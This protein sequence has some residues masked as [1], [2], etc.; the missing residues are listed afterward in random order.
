MNK[1]GQQSEVANLEEALEAFL[2]APPEGTPPAVIEAFA[3]AVGQGGGALPPRLFLE[4]VRQSAVAIS[5][6]DPKANIL[7]ANPAFG[8]VTG[9]SAEDIVGKNE[10]LL[11]DKTTPSVVYETMWGRLL[12]K[13]SWS[14]V[15][16]NRRK[17]GAR[18]LAELTI[19]PVLD[20]AGN[21]THYLGMHRDVTEVHRLEQQVK[22]QKALIESMVDAAPVA[23]ALLD[24]EGRVVLDNMA[25]KTLS[26]EMGDAEPAE[27]FL[28][29][30]TRSM[31]EAFE[32]LKTSRSGFDNKEVNFEPGNGAPP[33]WFSCSGTWFRE[34]DES[35][36][37]FFEARKETYLLLVA[38][39]IT[40]LKQQQE[41]VRM[42]ALGA[43]LAE[44]ELV[45]GM[46]ET[47]AGAV[48]QL[49][50][51]CNLI[52]AATTMMERR[53]ESKAKSDDPLLSVMRETLSAGRDAIETL[54]A[55]MP[56]PPDE[57]SVSVNINQVI[58]E[59]LTLCTQ[60]M[61][62]S[63]VVVDWQPARVLP[64]LSAREGRLRSMFKQL[65]DNAIDAMA[66]NAGE[67]SVLSI[68]TDVLDDTLIVHLADTGPGIPDD[69]HIKVFEPFYTTKGAAGR[70]AGMGLAMVQ[71]VVNEHAGTID[72]DADYNEGCRFVI[73]LPLDKEAVTE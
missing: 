52:N 3:D 14:G 67:E 11:S 12:Q 39:E 43:L 65:I 32:R 51:P 59:V 44:E 7:Y 27:V 30:L 21:T 13:K 73:R 22:N 71:E 10:S 46:R 37:A 68:H 72:I 15:L 36:D 31:G 23:I 40:L 1:Q 24:G 2:S 38:N 16:V 18:Y 61:L 49:Q 48:Y 58:R 62:A 28:D 54:Q 9:Y 45:Q 53:I 5:I 8:R 35:A 34:R 57:P 33:R 47:L 66:Q 25:Y 56:E 60:R 6:T 55:C 70:R 17:D 63:G 20:A 26:A 41:E 4:V 69:L 42:A 19:A 50:G 64:M 29:A